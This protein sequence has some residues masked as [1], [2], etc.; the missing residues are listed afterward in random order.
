MKQKLSK[1]ISAGTTAD[2]STKDNGMH[3]SPANAKPFK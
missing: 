1:E 3:V 2:S